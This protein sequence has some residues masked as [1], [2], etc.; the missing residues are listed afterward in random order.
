M[1][2]HVGARVRIYLS[3]RGHDEGASKGARIG[4]CESN[5][6]CPSAEGNRN[7]PGQQAVFTTRAF[8]ETAT[9]FHDS[10]D[11]AAPDH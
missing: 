6:T 8:F 9:T 5:Y 7:L 4:L 3:L 1:G 10:A 11:F 2:T